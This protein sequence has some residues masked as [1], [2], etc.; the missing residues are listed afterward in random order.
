MKSLLLTLGLLA[1]APSFAATLSGL[2]FGYT[3]DQNNLLGVRSTSAVQ[4]LTVGPGVEVTR[5]LGVGGNIDVDDTGFSIYTGIN[6][7]G[8]KGFQLFDLNNIL[9]DITGLTLTVGPGISGFTSSF[10]ANSITLDWLSNSLLGDTIRVDI[11]VASNPV[12]PPPVSAVPLPGAA[13]LM[14][15]GLGMLAGLR[16][17][18]QKGAQPAQPALAA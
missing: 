6:L 18:G 11:T 10:T 5:L 1:A 2:E 16:R 4:N 3:T 15:G 12:T 14:L 13:T 9:N 8:L 17:R 7:S